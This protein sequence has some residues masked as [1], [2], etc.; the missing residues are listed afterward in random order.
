MS[1]VFSVV[2]L[3]TYT[4]KLF[5]MYPEH[6]GKS[7]GLV[8]VSTIEYGPVCDKDTRNTDRAICNGQC[9]VHGSVT[10]H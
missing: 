1:V 6:V 7:G 2:V 9:P 4:Y 3:G 5:F 10:R 8:C